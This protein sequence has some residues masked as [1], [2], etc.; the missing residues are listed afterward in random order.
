MERQNQE[1]QQLLD[2]KSR[3][4]MEIETYR[5]LLEGEF[6]QS[7]SQSSY[8]SSSS[9]G[10]STAVSSTQ[11]STTQSSAASV[12][13]KKDPTKTRKVK[14]IVEEVIDGKVVSSQ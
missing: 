5:R 13:S 9:S 6:G 14:T 10:Q 12:E 11:V 1:Y 7:Q 3:L 8:S 2:I 4:E